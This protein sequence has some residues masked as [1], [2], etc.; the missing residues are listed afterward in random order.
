MRKTAHTF[1][2]LS[3]SLFIISCGSKKKERSPEEK[4]FPILAFLQSQVARVDTSL[5]NIVKTVT[6]GDKTDTFYINRENFKTE[7]AEF[8][9]VPDIA[10][11]KYEDDYKETQQFDETLNKVI[12]SYT[13]VDPD[14][15]EIIKQD[16][17]ITPDLVSGD[18]VNNIYI[19]SW[20]NKKDSTIQ[21]RMLW[22]VDRYFQITTIVQPKGGAERVT[23]IRLTWNEE[24]TPPPSPSDTIAIKKGDSTQ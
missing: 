24:R 21:K 18:K 19:D 12:M 16:I 5:Y 8:L 10:S 4:N 3:L 1:V 14:D 15:D 6:T 17:T 22:M 13:P 23:N 2:V 7:A 11:P 9:S 20:K